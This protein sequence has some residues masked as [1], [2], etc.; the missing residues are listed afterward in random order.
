MSCFYFGI[1]RDLN[2]LYSQNECLRDGWFN[3]IKVP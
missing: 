2:F 3:L 1:M